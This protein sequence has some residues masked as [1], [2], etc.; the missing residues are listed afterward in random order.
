MRSRDDFPAPLRPATI[1]P[2]PPA[3]EKLIPLKTS[4]PPRRHARSKA[5]SRIDVSKQSNNFADHIGYSFV[6]L[7]QIL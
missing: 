6:E 4:R 7:E 1:R 3:S 2:S 5:E